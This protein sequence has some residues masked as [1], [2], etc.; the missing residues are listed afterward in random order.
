[1]AVLVRLLCS[2]HYPRLDQVSTQSFRFVTKRDWLMCDEPTV[3]GRGKDASLIRIQS[4]I[5]KR[6][7]VT[8]EVEHLWA[9]LTQL[10]NLDLLD[11]M[12]SAVLFTIV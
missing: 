8:V 11:E 4:E 2:E 9:R 3:V 5:Y 6:L 1:M 12:A 10:Y 7:N